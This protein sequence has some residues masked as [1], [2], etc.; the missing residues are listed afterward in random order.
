MGGVGYIIELNGTRYYIAGDTDINED[1]IKVSCD[2]ALIPVGGTYTM[3]FKEAAE[4]V[5]KIMPETAIPTH[6]GSIAGEMT[7]GES[8]KALVK[9][10]IK[11]EIITE[12]Y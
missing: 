7:D 1:N 10:Q 5:N 11:C 3:N 12:E 2:T 4:L 8:F 6:F 9:S